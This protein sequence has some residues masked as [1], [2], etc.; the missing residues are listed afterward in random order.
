MKYEVKVGQPLDGQFTVTVENTGTG[1]APVTIVV[2]SGQ[3]PQKKEQPSFKKAVVLA[4]VG[5]AVCFLCASVAYGMATG[6]FSV[7]KSFAQT[8]IELLDYL[9]KLAMKNLK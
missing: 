3:Q 6:D 4:V 8:G 2:N 1:N 9:V 7:V 5:L